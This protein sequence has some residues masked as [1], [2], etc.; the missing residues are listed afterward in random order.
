MLQLQLASNRFRFDIIT[1]SRDYKDKLKEATDRGL[2]FNVCREMKEEDLS[3]DGEYIHVI[4]KSPLWLKLRSQAMT[5][6]SSMGKYIKAPTTNHTYDEIEEAWKDKLN[7]VG[8]EKTHVVRGHMNWGV[9]YEDP[10]LIDFA[11]HKSLSVAQVG[12]I[13]LPVSFIGALYRK[14]TG[15]D[16]KIFSKYLDKYFLVSPDGVVYSE[17]VSNLTDN[18][19]KLIPPVGMLEIKCISPFFHKE[20]ADTQKL[21]WVPNMNS[22][23]WFSPYDIPWVYLVQMCLQAISGVHRFKMNGDRTMWFLR[24]SPYGFSVFDLQFKLLVRLG[25][26]VTAKFL[27]VYEATNID[28]LHTLR[29]LDLTPEIS[30]LN[31]NIQKIYGEIMSTTKHSYIE[32]RDKFSEFHLYYDITKNFEFVVED[33]TEANAEEE[34]TVGELITEVDIL[35]RP[36]C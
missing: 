31:K 3:S 32:H 16:E 34:S 29:E 23:Q 35:T 7:G 15:E 5:T 9:G 10:A 12:T 6:A 25:V 18:S 11:L 20:D 27:R 17:G 26:Y 13:K 8:F 22:R 19:G 36:L 24:W 4:Q 1:S 21:T 30:A 14:L 2:Y 28:N 33:E